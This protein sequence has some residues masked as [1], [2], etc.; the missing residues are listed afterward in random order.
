MGLDEMSG[1]GGEN[2]VAKGLI[3]SLPDC[4][5]ST[6]AYQPT[7][8]GQ[9]TILPFRLKTNIFVHRLK[10][11]HPA[12]LDLLLPYVDRINETAPSVSFEAEADISLPQ[13]RYLSR[14]PIE[15]AREIVKVARQACNAETAPQT[16]EQHQ[17]D[18]IRE[19]SEL[20]LFFYAGRVGEMARTWSRAQRWCVD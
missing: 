12:N 14:L 5:T 7:S 8:E 17:E 11:D 1:S 19:L 10:N 15:Q 3:G 18:K 9:P 20:M 2:D 13:S 6:A 16:K 4:A